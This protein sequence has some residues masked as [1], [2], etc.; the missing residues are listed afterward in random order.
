MP[1]AYISPRFAAVDSFGNPLVGGRLYTYAN[2]TTT[3]QTTYQDAAGT[4][5]NTNPIILDSRGEAVI[6]L[7]EGVVYTWVLKDA[8]DALIWSQSDIAGGKTES[9]LPIYPSPPVSFVGNL[10]YIIP[11]GWSTWNGEKYVSDYSNGFG[12]GQYTLRNKLIN[13]DFRIA[14]RGSAFGGITAASGNPYTLDRWKVNISGAASVSLTRVSGYSDYGQGRF[15]FY[16][17][18]ITSDLA[19]STASGDKN[20]FSQLIEGQSILS[21]AMGTI[22]PGFITLSFWVRASI[23][24]T[25]SVAFLNSG[26]PGFRSYIANYTVNVAG[27][28][29]FKT[30]TIPIEAS[31]TANWNSG[32]GIGLQVAFDLGSGSTYEGP[33]NTWLSTESTRTTGSVRITGTIGAT[34]DFSNVQLEIGSQPT[35]FE[36]RPYGLENTLCQRYFNKTMNGVPGE[37]NTFGALYT[38]AGNSNIGAMW[39]F[40]SEMR[41]TPTIRR[42]APDAATA[43]WSTNV[44]TPAGGQIAVGLRNV[45]ITGTGATVGSGYLIHV[46]ADAEL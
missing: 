22:W 11:R 37:L 10:I 36:E 2:N 24:G 38:L 20:R 29:E 35:P 33:V 1:T 6:F 43:N 16:G 21:F 45:A 46:T 39:N 3:P 28:V 8:N 26:S 25:Y 9:N 32:N 30:V 41:A 19:A 5:A 15:G 42:Y 31:G 27:A 13:G 14:Q 7:S 23:A 34:I 17:A 18:R 40:P 4:I 44:T 12:S